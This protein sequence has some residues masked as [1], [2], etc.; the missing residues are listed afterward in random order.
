MSADGRIRVVC[1]DCNATLLIPAKAV[2]QWVT[3]PKC[4]VSFVAEA[5]VPTAPPPPPKPTAK[6]VPVRRDAEEDDEDEDDR[7]RRKPARS[8]RDDDD[9]E[10]DDRPRRQPARSRRDDDDDDD[11]DDR[12]RRRSGSGSRP[13]PGKCPNCGST[14]S[15]K[16][17]FT[18]WGGLL[19]PIIFGLVRCGR[20]GQ[21]YSGRK[22]TPVG[23]T[24]ILIYSAVGGLIGLAIGVAIVLA[25]K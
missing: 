17:S 15:S 10:D 3:C 7:P 23:A 14:R 18:W 24:Q 11:D 25:G 8:R 21:Q 9:D 19:G 16:V 4:S 20:C 13:R 5:D 2:G 6:A 12:P 22:G 1:Q